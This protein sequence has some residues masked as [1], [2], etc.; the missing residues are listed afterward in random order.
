MKPQAKLITVG[1][2]SAPV[3]EDGLCALPDDSVDSTDERTGDH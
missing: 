1:D 2:S 3:C